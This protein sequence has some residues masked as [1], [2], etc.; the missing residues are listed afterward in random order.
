[1][2]QCDG[3]LLIA[4]SSDM[5]YMVTTPSTFRAGD[6]IVLQ[7]EPRADDCTL[8]LRPGLSTS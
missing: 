6:Q 1:M 3:D 8:P 7:S 5:L 2:E 4:A